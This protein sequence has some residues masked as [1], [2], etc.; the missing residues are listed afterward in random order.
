M[1]IGWRLFATLM[2][3]QKRR[4]RHLTDGQFLALC[5]TFGVPRKKSPENFFRPKT[6]LL[7]P[8]A[9][10]ESSNVSGFEQELL[11]DHLVTTNA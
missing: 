8:A 7:R 5:V 9:G 10:V 11:A 4:E 2:F 3:M 1:T 6:Q